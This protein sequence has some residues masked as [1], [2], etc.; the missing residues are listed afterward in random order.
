MTSVQGA[1]MSWGGRQQVLTTQY[2]SIVEDG[3]PVIKGTIK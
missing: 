1:E 2:V 3:K